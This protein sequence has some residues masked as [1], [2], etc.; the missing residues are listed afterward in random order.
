MAFG[1]VL[2]ANVLFRMPLCDTLLRLAE[3][4][5]FDPFW[6][7]RILDE[8]SR[9]LVSTLGIAQEKAERR[10]RLMCEA[11]DAAAVPAQA[12]EQLEPA[13]TN[14]EKDRH[15]LAAAVASGAQVVVTLN[16]R[17]FPDAA[18]EP[19]GVEALHPDDFLLN[20]HDLDPGA[21]RA[22]V[23]LQAAELTD[24]AMTVDEVLDTLATVVPSFVRAVRAHPG[25]GSS[26]WRSTSSS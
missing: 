4:E 5:L 1:A 22:V 24:P 16:L 7:D 17:D 6:S 11:F 26:P 19:L 20:L 14:D 8:M 12:I 9:N 3:I 21:V 18:C 10:V 15:V 23:E 25:G 2:D 13:M